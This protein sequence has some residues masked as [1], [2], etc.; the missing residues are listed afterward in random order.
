MRYLYNIVSFISHICIFLSMNVMFVLAKVNC[1]I[2][3]IYIVTHTNLFLRVN[4]SLHYRCIIEF[5]IMFFQLHFVI[6]FL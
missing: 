3:I 2:I 1:M 4:N 5:I 6:A